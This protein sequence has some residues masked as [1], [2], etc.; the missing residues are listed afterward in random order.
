MRRVAGLGLANPSAA[1]YWL[2]IL[3]VNGEKRRSVLRRLVENGKLVSI[4]IE[5]LSKRTFFMRTSDLPTLKIVQ[6]KRAPKARAAIIAALDN[7][8]WDRDL[9]RWVFDF[10][11]IWEVYK[12]ANKRR[13]GYYV[14]PVLYGERF[15]ARFDPAFEKKTRQLTIVNWW[16]E[17][18][19]QQDERM[20][21]ELTGCLRQFMENL[22]VSH[23]VVGEKVKGDKNLHWLRELEKS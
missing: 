8:M 19:V 23:L 20:E 2:G 9:M 1:Q 5:D 13:H 22:E 17:A 4:A 10:D 21:V 3:N 16:W 15:V 14:L 18:E 7:L 12:P 11:Y 6:S